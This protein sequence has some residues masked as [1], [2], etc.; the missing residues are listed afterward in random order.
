MNNKKIFSI[1]PA[2]DPSNR[3]TFLLDWELTMKCNLDCDYCYTGL[4]FGGHNNTTEH[5]P[6]EECL[7]T[8]DFMYAYVDKYMKKKPKWQRMVVLNVYGGESIFHPDIVEILTAV[9]QKHSKYADHWPLTVTCTTNAVAGKLLW[10]EVTKLI[11]E[12]TISFH[13][14]ALPKQRQQILDNILY[15]KSI[16]KRQK[17]VFVMHNDQNF[18][19]ISCDAI[20]FCK[21]ENIKHVVKVNDK[22]SSF[23]TRWQYSKD[24]YQYLSEYFQNKTSNAF[25]EKLKKELDK[26]ES[27]Q[28]DVASIGR[29]CCG[30]RSLC[31][32][33]EMKNTM[34]FVPAAGFENWY[35]SVNWYFLFVKQI[36]GNVYFNKDCRVS[37]DGDF[38][39][40]GNLK[41]YQ[42]ILDNL[43]NML[44]GL[45]IPVVQCIKS[46]C[47][48]G[49]CAPKASTFDNFKEIMKKHVVEDVHFQTNNS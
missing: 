34:S 1:E 37:L 41:N 22:I 9:R 27:A 38:E 44:N 2:I 3:P 20:E 21:K 35:C 49:Y 46:R 16:N 39:P 43:D 29:S 31:V 11:D 13:S 30:G 15:N 6:L 42:R 23:I 47:I 7:K 4:E 25:K 8:I 14:T 18:W 33:S 5:P 36:N 10:K 48:C 12:F 17:V 40:I 19:Q 24:Q 26:T 45:S 28:V 32:N